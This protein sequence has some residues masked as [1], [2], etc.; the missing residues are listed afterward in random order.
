MDRD[1]RGPGSPSGRR[2]EAFLPR[3]EGLEDRKLLT[4]TSVDLA[5]IQ[6]AN[7]GYEL[8]GKSAT[9]GAGYS[10]T[11]VGNVTGSTGG[12]G[13]DSIVI[14]APSVI[15][16]T[17]AGIAAGVTESAAYLVLGTKPVNLTAT[18][19]ITNLLTGER[20][21]DLGTL[22]QINQVNPTV[23]QPAPPANPILGFN[24]D[25]LT[26]VTGLDAATGLGRNSQ[27]GY[28]VAGASTGISGT[29]G[30]S[31]MIG[32]PNDAGGGRAFVIDGGAAL[33]SQAITAKTID[34]EPTPGVTT[35]LGPTKIV[36][37]SLPN[38]G[39]ARVGNS[40]AYVPNFFGGSGGAISGAFVIGAPGVNNNTGA[41][42][43]VSASYVSTLASGTNV[44][45]STIGLAGGQGVVYTG[46]NA[47]DLTGF[48]VASAGSFDGFTTT[49]GGVPFNDLLIGA[50]GY[51]ANTGRA[52]LVYA[53]QTTAANVAIGST[54]SL[55]TV[56]QVPTLIP[57]TTPIDGIVFNGVS[58][59]AR[60]GYS[61]AQTGRGVNAPGTV[62]V[63]NIAIGAPGSGTGVSG[64]AATG[65]VGV[66]YGQAT[67]RTGGGVGTVRPIGIFPL[68]PTATNAAITT[69]YVPGETAGDL[70]G[71]SLAQLNPN[72][73]AVNAIVVGAPGFNAQ[74]GAGYSIPLG[75]VGGTPLTGVQPLSGTTLT[76]RRYTISSSFPGNPAALGTSVSGV[77]NGSGTGNS[78]DLFLGAPGF[79][80]TNPATGTSAGRT[81]DG[82][83]FAINQ[84]GSTPVP[85]PPPPPPPNPGTPPVAQF[86]PT[87]ASLLVVP[88]FNGDNAGLVFP[89]ATSL[90][91]LSSY[92]PLPVQLAYDQF[93][94]NQGFRA[95]QEVYHNPGRGQAHQAPAG[96]V[97]NVAAI[98][99]SE[100]R[101]AR[102]NLIPHGVLVADKFRHG[103]SITFTH[104][105]K[106][107]PRAE[108]TQTFRAP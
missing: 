13:L 101:F 103:Q 55:G 46:V 65:F 100:N 38:G 15:P 90:S 4:V 69:L 61:L 97:L 64:S 72:T 81:L 98:H 78:G 16:P 45:L 1:N 62:T 5:G 71:Y 2:R 87:A 23:L 29:G 59:G 51:A 106:V 88:T 17:A 11:N 36:S 104:N 12:T 76:A 93:L 31:I 30:S 91:H 10:I 66:V 60:L 6:T 34:L 20:A 92:R 56:G 53:D 108:Q 43:V 42:Y 18:V 8:V 44:D 47:G 84:A 49:T 7:L 32:A 22:G 102:R 48:S 39:T 89:T 68:D 77:G 57:V 95:R 40:V 24:Y 19:G 105:V 28:S 25:G 14:G 96:S 79:T 85:P 27:L 3:A 73:P 70:F 82:A 99:Y 9:N 107:I 63:S 35:N 74:S 67:S 37:F 52:Y 58:P 83:G 94:P 41:V 75:T 50:P 54:L 21:G 33:G 80:L 26:L 86:T